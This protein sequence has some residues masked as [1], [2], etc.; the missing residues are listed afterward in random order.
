ME[1]FTIVVRAETENPIEVLDTLNAALDA[2][3]WGSIR[4]LTLGSLLDRKAAGR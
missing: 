3:G 2:N 1:Q 4:T